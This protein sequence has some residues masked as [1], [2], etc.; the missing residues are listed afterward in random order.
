MNW[1]K[2]AEYVT[3][4]Y[5]TNPLEVIAPLMGMQ[6]VFFDT[7]STGLDPAID[8][9]TEIAA[10]ATSSPN[11][12][13]EATFH[14]KIDLTPE[15]T[16]RMEKE[17]DQG[18]G[19][20]DRVENILEMTQY[21]TL[22]MTPDSE[23]KVLNEFKAFL[24]KYPGPIVAHNANF[25]VH[26]VAKRSGGF[27]DRK[28]Y[29]TM[30]LTRFYYI[31]A[32]TVIAQ[33]NEDPKASEAV[34]ALESMTNK[35]GKVSSSLG[36]VAKALNIPIEGWHQA[37]NDVRSTIAVFA[38]V[39][40]YIM[41]NAQIFE[42]SDFLEEYKERLVKERGYQTKENLKKQRDRKL[43]KRKRVKNL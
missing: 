33:T 7:E 23:Q 27:P 36:F 25:D 43:E 41:Q 2:K 31:P 18:Y 11:F 6:L 40:D 17:K 37:I 22:E 20:F 21:E 35:K 26:I 1:Y 34:K 9:I 13:E 28:V 3:A 19:E 4:A 32:L 14:K 16:Q 39:T 8:Q 24:E 5:T 30:Y 15:I 38:G 12:E 42:T 10:I 29:D